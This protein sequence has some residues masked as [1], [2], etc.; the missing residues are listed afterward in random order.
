VN[1]LAPRAETR[2]VRR[3]VDPS[4][5]YLVSPVPT[6]RFNSMSVLTFAGAFLPCFLLQGMLW[7]QRASP[8][9]ELGKHWIRDDIEAAFRAAEQSGKP[10][11]ALFR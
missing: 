2:G 10:I 8:G 7:A 6:G 4:F 11:L 1:F 3:R 9:E 5:W